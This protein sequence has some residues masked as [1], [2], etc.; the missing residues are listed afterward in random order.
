MEQALIDTSYKGV[1]RLL[2]QMA[3]KGFMRLQAAKI[4]G[5]DFDD[6]MG[7]M[8]VAY[9]KAA[10]GF[11]Q[12]SGGRFTTYCVRVCWNEFN[13]Y[14]ERL[15]RE[16]AAIGYISLDQIASD[17]SGGD[18]DFD[19]MDCLVGEADLQDS[20]EDMAERRQ[21]LNRAS[22]SLSKE[23]K[24][25]LYHLLQPNA[26]LLK[27]YNAEMEAAWA[28]RVEDPRN[29]R[30]ADDIT[31][32]FIGKFYGIDKATIAEVKKE[33]GRVYGIREWNKGSNGHPT[34]R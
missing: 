29:P 20:P 27:A 16:H 26:K 25:V 13:K 15:T 8:R 30:K 33:L 24:T 7:E 10:N 19:A 34:Y 22:K 18:D 17:A 21:T 2:L 3:N 11:K 9:V 28:G 23:S 5:A 32:K 14:A 1:E 12:D 4:L 6:V 31:V